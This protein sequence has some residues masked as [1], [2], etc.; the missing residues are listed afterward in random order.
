ME[1]QFQKEEWEEKNA[2]KDKERNIY[3]IKGKGKQRKNNGT[4]RNGEKYNM[5]SNRTQKKEKKDIDKVT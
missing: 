2:A 1:I 5:K 4:E 3:A